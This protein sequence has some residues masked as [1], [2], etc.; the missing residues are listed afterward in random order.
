M[1]QFIPAYSPDFMP[2]EE[3]FS[4]VKYFLE[5][6]EVLYTSTDNPSLHLTMTFAS[7]TRDDCLGYI[8]HAGYCV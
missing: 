2:L 7:V 4:Q 5:K 8:R 1:I 6:S 3:V